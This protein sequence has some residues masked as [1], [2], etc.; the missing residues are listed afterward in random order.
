[1]VGMDR[2]RSVWQGV[3]TLML[4]LIVLLTGCSI[5]SDTP[6]AITLTFNAN[7]SNA[8]GSMATLV[9]EPG[10]VIS[11]PASSF[12]LAGGSFS[13]WNSGSDGSGTAYGDEGEFTMG[14]QSVILYARWNRSVSL[15]NVPMGI[16][17]AGGYLYV[18]SRDDHTIL[19][20]DPVTLSDSV[21]AGS[22]TDDTVDGTGTAA[23][24]DKPVEIAAD[25]SFLYVSEW[26]GGAVRKIS[27][28]TAEVT[29]VADG[30]Q[31]PRAV[32]VDGDHLFVVE[33]AADRLNHIR[34]STQEKTVISVTGDPIDYPLDMVACGDNLFLANYDDNNIIEIACT[35]DDQGAVSSAESTVI[36][37]GFDTPLGLSL[38]GTELYITSYTPGKVVKTD[39]SPG[40]TYSQVTVI[41]RIT[42]PTDL[43]I[44]GEDLFITRSDWDELQVEVLD[45]VP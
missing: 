38:D 41:D 12:T 29:T 4:A 9:L 11:L 43:V 14:A 37:D 25:E 27:L 24:F 32:A 33:T 19:K 28:E 22:G 10:E 8:E 30:L 2:F 1:M 31:L 16:T 44:L 7:D 26:G 39:I 40:S 45:R 35:Y 36:L 21:F 18:A 13:H 6:D 34:L 3:I 42:V 5:M 23:S 15:G 20:V 17:A